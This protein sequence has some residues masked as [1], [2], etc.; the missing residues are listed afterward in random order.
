MLRLRSQLKGSEMDGGDDEINDWSQMEY[1]PSIH[2]PRSKLGLDIQQ[3][4]M[5][6]GQAG[7]L[8]KSTSTG[9]YHWY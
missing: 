7:W 3:Y 4:V 1:T 5:A 2:T 8:K 6:R 9:S